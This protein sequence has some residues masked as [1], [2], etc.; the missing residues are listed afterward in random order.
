MKGGFSLSMTVEAR[1][2]TNT[3]IK[4]GFYGATVSSVVIAQVKNLPYKAPA[5]FELPIKHAVVGTLGPGWNF[6]LRK[7]LYFQV[8]TTFIPS[9][10]SRAERGIPWWVILVAVLAGLALLVLLILLMWRVS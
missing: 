5:G 7:K 4:E 9:D 1:L 10:P 8:T 2:W 6:L 3:L